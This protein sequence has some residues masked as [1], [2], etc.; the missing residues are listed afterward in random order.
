MGRG[1]G[2]GGRVKIAGGGGDT[3]I[4]ETTAPAVAN[5][6]AGPAPAGKGIPESLPPAG[7]DPRIRELPP[8]ANANRWIDAEGR[9]QVGDLGAPVSDTGRFL[10]DA[11]A[12]D[13]LLNKVG[14]PRDV[15][16]RLEDRGDL[17]NIA[18]ILP[19]GSKYLGN[20]YEGVGIKVPDGKGGF[21]SY[22]VQYRNSAEPIAPYD[23]GRIGVYPD[24]K[25]KYGNTWVEQRELIGT[26]GKDFLAQRGLGA[27]K[28]K[29]QEMFRNMSL[30][31]EGKPYKT[32]QEW[33]GMFS[34]TQLGRFNASA[35]GD[36]H[37][38]NWG[39]D[40][41]GIARVFDPGA[42]QRE[43]DKAVVTWQ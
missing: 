40:S 10:V 28:V 25:K 30:D 31:V 24:W 36:L 27:V 13:Y 17:K 41:R 18:G 29:Y 43:G 37:N 42:A 19:E 12:R 23:I 1:G 15:V 26:Q 39:I 38:G 22:R 20:G 35:G 5:R 14:M 33:S 6:A 7:A 4:A 2:G 34:G 21:T 16:G 9:V 8:V 11:Q 32:V 3:N